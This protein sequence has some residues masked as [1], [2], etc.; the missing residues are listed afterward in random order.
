MKSGTKRDLI[1]KNLTSDVRKVELNQANDA[2][3]EMFKI[4]GGEFKYENNSG[5]LYSAAYVIIAIVGLLLLIINFSGY[6]SSMKLLVA[7]ALLFFWFSFK[8]ITTISKALKG[9]Y[10]EE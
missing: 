10:R 1:I 5:Y 9:K 4:N 6:K 7:G 2:L 8:A 3:N